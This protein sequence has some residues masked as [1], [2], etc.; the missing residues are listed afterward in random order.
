M[1]AARSISIPHIRGRR[2]RQPP[3]SDAVSS[4]GRLQIMLF[5]PTD[6][7]P[8]NYSQDTL[9]PFKSPVHSHR[10]NI[11]FADMHVRSHASFDASEMTLRTGCAR[12][13][14]LK[15]RI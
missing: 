3:L 12:R 7:D 8:D 13:G 5:D 2:F 1:L 4:L 10:V 9:L 6:A 14:V 15:W 11:L